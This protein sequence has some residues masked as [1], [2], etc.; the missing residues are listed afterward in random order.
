MSR[1]WKIT[2]ALGLFLR[3]WF[4]RIR[5]FSNLRVLAFFTNSEHASDTIRAMNGESLGDHQIC[6]NYASKPVH[7]NRE[8]PL[9]PV[10]MVT[11]I[12]E[13]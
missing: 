4:S 6:V 1:L 9:G 2:L 5:R 8:V 10:G 13:G 7:G 11:D 12:P 3:W